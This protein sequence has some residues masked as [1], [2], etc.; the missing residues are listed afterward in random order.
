MNST[1]TTQR[2]RSKNPAD[3]SVPTITI[4]SSAN[5]PNDT[6]GETPVNVYSSGAMIDRYKP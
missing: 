4:P 1:S 2:T 6:N 3:C 5:G